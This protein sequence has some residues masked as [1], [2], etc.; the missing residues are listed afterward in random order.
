MDL[1]MTEAVPSIREYAGVVADATLTV[2]LA[3]VPVLVDDYILACIMHRSA[4]TIPSGWTQVDTA[5]PVV[6]D[7]TSQRVT[8]LA[9]HAGSA[10][11]VTPQFT[12]ASSGRMS[13][14]VFRARNVVGLT[15]RSD[16]RVAVA[17]T[18]PNTH[19]S[20]AKGTAR[21]LVW[22]VAST[23]YAASSAQWTCS[24]SSLSPTIAGA[25]SSN[26]PRLG[27]FYDSDES[28]TARTFTPAT[29]SPVASYLQVVAVEIEG[30]STGAGVTPKRFLNV[31]GAAE[32][33]Q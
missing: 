25:T 30:L 1:G 12:Q 17:S 6:G 32:P 10:E 7:A 5:G 16:L 20:A 33:I 29:A 15:T 14:A 2:S 27:A 13:A 31:G 23:I 28:T 11:S 19:V 21:T 24:A 9:Y 18:L 22:A 26:A 3:A 4:L 8:I